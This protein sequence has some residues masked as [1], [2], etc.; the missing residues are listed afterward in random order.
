MFGPVFCSNSLRDFRNGKTSFS[1]LPFRFS[2][3]TF[4]GNR[5]VSFESIVPIT[6]ITGGYSVSLLDVEGNRVDSFESIVPITGGYSVSLLDVEGNRVVSFESIV[7]ITRITGGYSV[8]L[9]DV[10]VNM[11]H[12]RMQFT[13]V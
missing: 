2:Y 6:S 13:R 11:I 12:V 3:S 8:S 7:P 1:P 10:E 5:V 4:R 9:L